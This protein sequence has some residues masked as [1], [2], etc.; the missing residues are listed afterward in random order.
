MNLQDDRH[1][2]RDLQDD[3]H[4]R[5]NIN[6]NVTCPNCTCKKDET[7]K[8]EIST[9]MRWSTNGLFKVTRDDCILT[10]HYENSKIKKLKCEDICM[11]IKMQE[12]ISRCIKPKQ[13]WFNFDD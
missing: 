8:E 2:R 9:E 7:N 11:A 12:V 6:I 3:R 10:L 4:S 1:S 5:M 13:Y